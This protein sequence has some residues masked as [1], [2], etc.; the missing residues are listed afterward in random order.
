ML[1]DIVNCQGT[2]IGIH[3]RS[4][5]GEHK[6]QNTSDGINIPAGR[7]LF[8]MWI[9]SFCSGIFY[10]CFDKGGILNL[11]RDI[12]DPEINNFKERKTGYIL[13][14]ADHNIIWF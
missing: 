6:I 4:V 8:V 11:F 13:C 10:M 14:T 1:N 3:I 5:T 9:I 7:N 2:F 12:G